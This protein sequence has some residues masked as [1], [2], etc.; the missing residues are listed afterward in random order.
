MVEGVAGLSMCPPQA[1]TPA[2]CGAICYR[3]GCFSEWLSLELPAHPVGHDQVSPALCPHRTCCLPQL[4]PPG[5]LSRASSSQD[6]TASVRRPILL[7]SLAAVANEGCGQPPP[8]RPRPLKDRPSEAT[9]CGLKNVPGFRQAGTGWRSALSLTAH[10]PH[11]EL[12]QA[13]PRFT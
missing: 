7:W 13:L 3:P 5:I 9:A 12:S 2:V 8:P 4:P 10:L 6:H 1:P 11:W